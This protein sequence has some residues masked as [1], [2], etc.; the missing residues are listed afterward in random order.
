MPLLD[1]MLVYASHHVIWI[2]V[3]HRCL[4]LKLRLSRYARGCGWLSAEY[5]TLMNGIY[6]SRLIVLIILIAIIVLFF[7]STI[8]MIVVATTIVIDARNQSSPTP[9]PK[10]SIRRK[11]EH[12]AT[13]SPNLNPPKYFC[14]YHE[15][16]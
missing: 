13:N 3:K 11:V 8:V 1:V 9:E 7:D 14:Y 12:T 2:C 5:A 4:N 15:N 10:S 16:F 6:M